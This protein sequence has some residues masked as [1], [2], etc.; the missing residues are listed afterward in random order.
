MKRRSFIAMA[1][2][3]A[4]LPASVLAQSD[5][6]NRI[7]VGFAPGG[8]TDVVART[9]A[10]NLKYGSGITLV[11]NRAG[12]AGR[13]AVDFVK[14]ASGNGRTILMTP[15]SM[16]IIYPHVYK[17]LT[18]NPATDFMPVTSLVTITYAISVGPSVPEKVKTLAD[19]VQWCKANPKEAAYGSPGAGTAPHFLGTMLARS[20]GFEYLHIGYRGGALA[21]QDMMGGQIAS[22]INVISEVLPY[23]RSGKVRILAI[24]SP[25]R[26]KFLPDV[27]TFAEAGM[28]ELE[29]E[30]WFGV[31]LPA[32]ASGDLVAKLGAAVKEAF[33][34]P[35]VAET[36]EKLGFIVKTSTPAEFDARVKADIKRWGPI[37]KSTGFTLDE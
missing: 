34:R 9:L 37:V 20:G 16:M 19:F 18:Y 10:Q 25:Q 31:F 3:T 27:P 2:L 21:V 6:T 7:M 24:S 29:S 1:G 5:E 13:L 33:S 4:A 14:R 26:S 11:E 8:S 32:E 28:K 12:A 36:V 23:A 30:E 22:S 35:G 17:K 15:G